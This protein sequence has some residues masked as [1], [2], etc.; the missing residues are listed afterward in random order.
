PPAITVSWGNVSDH[1]L[2]LGHSLRTTVGGRVS[3]RPGANL[4]LDCPVT[5]PPA[6]TVSWGNVSDHGLVLGHSLRTTVG[7]RVSVRPGA[8]L[9]LDCPVTGVPQPTVTW[10]RKNRPLDAGTV[11]LP[12]GSLWIRNVSLH[13]QGTYS[14]SATNAI[15]KST[16]STVL[17]VY[18]SY[19]AGGGR[20]A[21][22]SQELNRRRVLM[23]SHRGTSVFI[24]PG[25]ILRI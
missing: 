11:S 14:C 24:K 13:N 19:P 15:G 7:G 20:V 18:G 1:G 21:P 22:V 10:N 8:N 2:V 6:I 17:Q 3:V 9:T 23:A 5:E 4:T 25:D 16:A 12:S